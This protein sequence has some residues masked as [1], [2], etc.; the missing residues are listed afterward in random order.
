MNVNYPNRSK[1]QFTSKQQESFLKRFGVEVLKENNPIR[2]IF[3]SKNIESSD[4]VSILLYVTARTSDLKQDDVFEYENTRYKV[5]YSEN[6]FSGLTNFYIS[7]EGEN[8][9]KYE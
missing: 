1:S 5:M 9:S 2:V 3:E 7:V 6:D 4:S 8:G